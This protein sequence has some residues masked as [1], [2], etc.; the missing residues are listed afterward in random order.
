M[1]EWGSFTGLLNK[2]EHLYLEYYLTKSYF[3]PQN[4]NVKL[5]KHG[6]PSV[7]VGSEGY[8]G[9]HIKH[10]ILMKELRKIDSTS[11]FNKELNIKATP[12]PMCYVCKNTLRVPII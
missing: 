9:C 11:L 7:L 4:I 10:K 3:L 2:F 12:S 1:L 8:F 6:F 5:K